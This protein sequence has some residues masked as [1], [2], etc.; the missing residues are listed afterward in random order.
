[1]E[2]TV[3]DI[4]IEKA[5]SSKIEQV[6]FNNL[7]FGSVFTDHMMVC[8]YKDGAWQTPKIIPYQPLTLEPSARVFHYGQAVFEGMKAYKDDDG[9]VWLFR[10]DENFH[11]INKSS[12]RMA[13]PEF[14]EDYFFDGLNTLLKME[15][16][17][18]KPGLGNS[19]Y[20]RPFAIAT[21]AG[22]IASPS[23][24]FKFLIICSPAQAYYGGEVRVKI[25]EKFSRAADGGFGF[26]KAAGNYAGQFYPTNLAKEE[27][28]QQIVWTDAKSHEFIE[29]AGTMNIF[30]RMG[31][32]LLTCPTGDRILDGV[33]RKSVIA[34]AEEQGIE[35]DIRPIR[36]SELLEGHKNG[37]LKEMFGSGTAAVI[38]P[39]LGFG[40][41]GERYELPVMTDS[42]ATR[43]K[44]QLINIQYNIAEDK[45]G[46]RYEVK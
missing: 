15:N 6:D 14:P 18:I 32:K 30:V 24:E 3:K 5:K 41:K 19:L 11:R 37:E 1:M 4:I 46:W 33:T 28:F 36:V 20:I 35:V 8:D 17:W 42:Y 7:P 12:A 27:G 34:L 21:Q 9:K 25:A 23:Q 39:I 26:A 10:P 2:S 45:F 16:D 43:I 40:Y 29:E 13:M 44:Q 22:I 31:D 38:N